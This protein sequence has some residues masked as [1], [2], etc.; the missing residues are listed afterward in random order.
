MTTLII[1]S[2]CPVQFLD[3]D[4]IIQEAMKCLNYGRKTNSL[5]E[6]ILNGIR[7][8]SLNKKFGMGSLKLCIFKK[9]KA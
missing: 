2:Y 3:V 7:P 4:E 1:T 9:S 6:N 5:N 8:E